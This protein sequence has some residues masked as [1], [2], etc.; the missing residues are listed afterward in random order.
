MV[1]TDC[2]AVR[3]QLR[4]CLTITARRAAE[5][6]LFWKT[7]P[8]LS[9]TKMH[10]STEVPLRRTH[11]AA[12]A[13]VAALLAITIAFP[14]AGDRKDKA[15][16]V[17]NE[18][19]KQID[20][21][22]AN[23]LTPE[24]GLASLQVA[25]GFR[26]ELVA[27]E[28]L[29]HDPI[30]IAWDADGRLYAVEL[31]GY[32]PDVDGNGEDAPV[33]RIVALED[34]DQD[35]AMDKSTV[36]LDGL[37]APRAIAIVKGGL[38][39]A[40]PPALWFCQDLDGDLTV[41]RKT[42]VGEYAVVGSVEH[43]ENGLRR[44]IDNW[45]YNAKSDRR[46]KWD[47]SQLRVEQT[48]S[49]GQWGLAMDD[50]G[51]LYNNSN[52]NPA[53][54]DF[55]PPEYGSRNPGYSP[56]A[57]I[58]V[59]IASSRHVFSNRVNPGVN[60]GYRGPTLRDDFR[61]NT[62]TAVS[63]LAI[64]RGDQYPETH[65]GNLFVPEPGANLLMRYAV[66]NNGLGI[67]ASKRLEDDPIW[68][69]IEFLASTDERFRPVDVATGP[70]GFLYIVDM[71]R[72]IL[73]HKVFV[74]T[75]LRK[76]IL[77]RGLD[78]PVGLGRIYRV[79]HESSSASRA[80]PRLS[81]YS[82]V[83]LVEALAS[84]NGWIRDTAQRLLVD[85]GTL[86]EDAREALVRTATHGS[87]I[88]AIHALWTL[89]GRGEL[90]PSTAAQA[91][92]HSSPWTRTHAIRVAES[93][94]AEERPD[95]AL[96]S[97]YENAFN[98]SFFRV[99]LQA[100]QTLAVVRDDAFVVSQ[101]KRVFHPD[102]PSDYM[103][104]ALVSSLS[105]RETRFIEA[106]M[107]DSKW[108]SGEGRAAVLGKLATVLFNKQDSDSLFA[109]LPWLEADKANQ[110]KADALVAGLA[111]TAGRP[112]S[113]PIQVDFK[114]DAFYALI[115][116]LPQEAADWKQGL[117]RA[118]T[119]SGRDSD[120]PLANLNR[121][122]LARIEKGKALYTATCMAC[123]QADGNG[124]PGLA[125]A[126]NGSDWVTQ[127]KERLALMIHHGISGPIEV[128]GEAWN[129]VMPGHGVMPQFEGDGLAQ[130]MS[131]IRTAWGN[132]ADLVSRSEIRGVIDAHT[133]RVLPWTVSELDELD[134][135]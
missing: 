135:K 88:P 13:I 84:R 4:N 42:N 109:L 24:E 34:T 44:G 26:V 79:V 75:Y 41:D 86:S 27:S 39:V 107:N 29:V 115:D 82:Q 22:P 112:E 37:V 10:L 98:D 125:P 108:I 6:Y 117:D 12:I 96:F 62:A 48:V 63:G 32:M 36:V 120:D 129:S 23:V 116:S 131:Y 81:E 110:W 65:Y 58:N 87:E 71:Y 5:P 49:R 133:D 43:R 53:R 91:L 78:T 56:Q 30:A 95:D 70:D 113:R 85:A 114:P 124:M 11:R 130:V 80:A 90:S 16:D 83:E 54:A 61:L 89:E 66:E 35:G 28:P 7:R 25:S 57:G 38:L 3:A 60:R 106:V 97:A 132:K 64:Y 72:G 47:G 102:L 55:Y 69:K 99:R 76:Q 77:E 15:G 9:I 123:H 21:P 45:L 8:F 121:K 134:L 128:K 73:Q 19:W 119:W 105:G 127:S 59:D 101:A 46:F 111:T 51:R 1:G 17:Q 126:L 14:Q 118:F 92:A 18:N 68:E 104:D 94:L 40:E 2:Q 31:R 100:A 93:A 67:V 33:G 52:S 103:E 74:T 50:Y 122:Q 20:V